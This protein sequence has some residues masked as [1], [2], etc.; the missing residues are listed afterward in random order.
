MTLA[1][2]IRGTPALL[3][4]ASLSEWTVVCG[5]CSQDDDEDEGGELVMHV[6]AADASA[7]AAQVGALMQGAVEVEIHCWPIVIFPGRH[8]PVEFTF[9][10]E[11]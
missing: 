1:D 11:L 10:E 7:A 8:E 6:F 4:P 2:E 3:Q 9:M 5:Y